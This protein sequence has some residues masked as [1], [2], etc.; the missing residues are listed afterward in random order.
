MKSFNV[1]VY[2][3]LINAENEILVSDE[4]RGDFAFT[5]FPGGG[6]EFGEGTKEALIRE[7]YEE[8]KIEISVENLFYVNDFFQVSAFNEK[9]QMLSFYYFV[10]YNKN[11]EI[12]QEQYVFPLQVN[13]EKQRWASIADLTEA[14]FTFPIDKVVIEKL[15]KN[16][17]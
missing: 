2:G 10:N 12:G 14:D 15:K 13:G 16:Q 8:L 9:H 6:L 3:L 7:F 1:R 11:D 17:N 5:K 4:R